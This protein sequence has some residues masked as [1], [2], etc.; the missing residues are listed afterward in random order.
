MRSFGFL[1]GECRFTY[2]VCWRTPLATSPYLLG[3]N[4]PTRS[5]FSYCPNNLL[6]RTHHFRYRL[7]V[8]HYIPHVRQDRVLQPDEAFSLKA[9]VRLI[10]R[11]GSNE[12]IDC[13][14]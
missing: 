7:L 4:P 6:Y 12:V 2:P 5:S 3:S 10:D 9:E 13:D 11:L 14:H 1:G 8:I